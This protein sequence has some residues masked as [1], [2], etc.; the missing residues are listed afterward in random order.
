MTKQHN[1]QWIDDAE[2]S[3]VLG[4]A[5]PQW[6]RD[7]YDLLPSDGYDEEMVY[8]LIGDLLVDPGMLYRRSMDGQSFL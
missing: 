8:E 6:I 7:V 1:T 4:L 5:D 3:R 2:F